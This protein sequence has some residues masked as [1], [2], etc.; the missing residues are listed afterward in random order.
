MSFRRLVLALPLLSLLPT[1]VQAGE[2]EAALKIQAGALVK[3]YGGTLLA[4]LKDSVEKSG[5]VAAL[6]VCNE[7]GPA[8]AQEMAT[9]SGWNIGRTSM[10]PRN[11]SSA[12]TPY[13]TGVMA[14]FE[15]RLAAGESVETL[16]RAETVPGADGKPV[17]HFIKAIPTG[18]LCL[19]CHGETAAPEITRRLSEL[20]PKDTATGFKLGQMRGVF[21]LSKAM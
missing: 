6:T 15:A 17:F 12:P 9:K 14:A 2:E 1:A 8:I 4:V 18:E 21:T 3:E 16:V 11:A 5:P 13:E 20:Y 10:K 7:R 19:T